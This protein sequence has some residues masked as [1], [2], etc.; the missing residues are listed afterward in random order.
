MSIEFWTGRPEFETTHEMAARD[1]L[2]ES[3]HHAFGQYDGLV[4]AVFDFS[5][6]Q[7][8]DLAV[9]KR[10]AITVV[11]L[12]QCSAP[13]IGGENGEWRV[14]GANDGV[15]VLKGGRHGNPFHQAKAYRFAFMDYL[16]QHAKKFLP[17]QKASLVRFDHVAAV[18]AVAPD[19]HP[20]S[21]LDFDWGH[22][23]WFHVTGLPQLSQKL[24]Q[25]RSRQIDLANVEIR[26]LVEDV[27]GCSPLAMPAE[28][29]VASQARKVPRLPEPERPPES[30][31]Q[32]RMKSGAEEFQ[33]A[34]D[35]YFRW[36]E[37]HP[38]GFV[39]NT[40]ASKSPQSMVLHSATCPM[41]SKYGKRTAS[42]GFT[43]R[44]YIKICAADIESL[45]TWVVRH[46]RP[47]G[48][49][50]GECGICKPA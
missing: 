14:M 5:C 8:L 46:G 23:T 20:G 26:R 1:Q 32:P 22:L 18:V 43:E 24:Y 21:R 44:Q 38:E 41:I 16:R 42:G 49:F 40:I 50:T 29:A 27:L 4:A 31:V 33:N 30:A 36:L 17:V 2:I 47:D 9:I 48:S 37:A 7:D 34:E 19:L 45:R 25:I 13:I 10:D 12:K 6:G 39:L 15:A 28:R 3:F 35:A 11:E